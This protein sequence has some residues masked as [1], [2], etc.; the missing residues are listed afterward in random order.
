[1]GIVARR[2]RSRSKAWSTNAWLQAGCTMTDVN[3]RLA[4]NVFHQALRVVLGGQQILQ[5]VMPEL[6]LILAGDGDAIDQDVV[7]IVNV[8]QPATARLDDEALLAGQILTPH[9]S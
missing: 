9:E 6:R 4:A 1:M 5:N 2:V 8:S 3:H 7:P